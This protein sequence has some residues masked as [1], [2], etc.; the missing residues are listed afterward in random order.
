M[1]VSVAH[2][3]EALA[4][5]G[6]EARLSAIIQRVEEISPK[7][8]P[9]DVGASVRARIQERCA[10]TASFKGGDDIFE[11]VHGVDARKGVWRL[12]SDPLSPNNPDNIYDGADLF[13]EASEGRLNLRVH[14][15][16]E[17]SRKLIENF[18]N[19]LQ[20]PKCEACDM[21][22]SD[23]YGDLGKGYIE[24][25]HKIPISSLGDNGRTKLSDLVALCAN[26]HRIIHKNNLMPVEELKR[27]L[28][29]RKK[30]N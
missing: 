25:H 26:C 12:K 22:F 28:L 17:R 30:S 5:L 23:V 15:R 4:S 21:R 1:P 19:S 29:M 20:D 24:A 6:G 7:P 10:Q 18:K 16:H 11:S 9:V 13:I 3:V 27:F 8:L 2:I 14:L